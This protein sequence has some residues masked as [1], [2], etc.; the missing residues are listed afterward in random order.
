MAQFHFV[1]GKRYTRPEVRAAVGLSPD[2]RGGPWY[3]GYVQHGLADFIF[4]NV[5]LPGRTGHDY[6]NFFDGEDLIWRGKTASHSGQPTIQRI[7]AA[8]AE[9]HIFWREEDR[10]PF[11]YAGQ[12]KAVEV[13][14]DSPVTVR[15]RFPA[16]VTVYPDDLP[17][18]P[19]APF[20]E[21]AAKAVTVNAF[22]RNPAARLTCILHHGTACKVCG[23]DFGKRY[24]A[25]GEGFIHVH[26]KT[27][28]AEIRQNYVID[29]VRDLVPVCPNC[30]AMLHRTMPP[31]T[32]EE[33]RA[34][35]KG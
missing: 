27:P 31:R 2:E 21:G 18:S 35:L 4:C 29:P 34:L 1:V 11:V 8:G 19:K 30:H 26:H 33:L 7:T 9:V 16:S 20:Q 12:A 5:G 22:E 23:L 10:A 14:S 32:V 13:G 6:N 28:L 17:D 24:G 3:T 25:L 15:W